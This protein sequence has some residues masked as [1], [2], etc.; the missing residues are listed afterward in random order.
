MGPVIAHGK[1]TSSISEQVI[2]SQLIG[3]FNSEG[4][5]IWVD[6]VKSLITSL[7]G[8][9]FCFLVDTRSYEG[10]TDEA[11]STANDFNGWLNGQKM[12]AKA[13]VIRSQVLHDIAIER[14]PHIKQQNVRTFKN[15]EDAMV[16]L[17]EELRLSAGSQV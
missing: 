1:H 15:Q 12:V 4:C 14:V 10:G 17:M 11:L 6:S 9:P 16:W 2:Q 8:R 7:D 13:H 3:A 5:R